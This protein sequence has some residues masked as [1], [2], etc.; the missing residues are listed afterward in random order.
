MMPLVDDPLCVWCLWEEQTLW[1]VRSELQCDINSSTS[2]DGARR[3]KSGAAE[4]HRAAQG[5][6][7]CMS[8]V[9]VV[10]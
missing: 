10:M 2:P 5:E 9:I 4:D 1:R 3:R 7:G 8:T 6:D